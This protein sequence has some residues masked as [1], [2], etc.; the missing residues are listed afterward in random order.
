PQQLLLSA[1]TWLSS[2]NWELKEKGLLSIKCLAISHSK[3]LL[4]RLREVSLAVI[5]EVTNLRSKVSHAAIITL[6]E[7]FVTLKKDMD[8]EVDEVAQVLLQMVWNSPEF[9]QK[10]ASQTLGIMVENVTPSRAMTALMDKGVQHRHVLVRK[11]AAKHLLAVM[12]K[13]G[14]KKLAATPTRAERLVH[15][16][17][18]LAQDCHKDTRYYGW[19][20]LHVLMS[21]Q[22]FNRLLEQAVST[23]DL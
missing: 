11:C 3:V 7:L 19:K 1:L 9:I 20:M 4:C 10:A 21:H 15:L 2:D 16:A 12:E 8:S 5:K 17:V 23:R 13:I 6:G 22:E 14:A 18:K